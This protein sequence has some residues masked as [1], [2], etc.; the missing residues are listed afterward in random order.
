MKSLYILIVFWISKMFGGEPKIASEVLQAKLTSSNSIYQYS[1]TDIDGKEVALS[2][3][4]GKVIV[5]VN[6]A[7]KCGL[8]PQYESIQKFYETYKDKNLVVLGF[9]A[10]NFM[11]QEP[12]NDQDIK[13]FCT[14]KYNVSFPM[15]SKIS[16]KGNDKHILYKHLT[17]KELNGVADSDVKWNFQKYIIN[18]EGMVIT[19]FSPQTKVDS[20]AFLAYVDSIIAQ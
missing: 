12:D 19:H 4:K 20:K 15:F 18:K 16:V 2:K 6:V 3:Y 11:G 5:I 8:T 17:T 13:S 14:N 10:N 9:P 1:V 7:S